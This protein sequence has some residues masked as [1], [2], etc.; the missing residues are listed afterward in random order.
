MWR[1]TSLYRQRRRRA[2]YTALQVGGSVL[3][4]DTFDAEEIDYEL[5]PIV[6]A[7]SVPARRHPGL[8]GVSSFAGQL[9]SP[10][11]P[12][13]FL[14]LRVGL[15]SQTYCGDLGN[16]QVDEVRRAVSA[17]ALILVGGI[18]KNT[19]NGHRRYNVVTSHLFLRNVLNE[20]TIR[21]YAI[22]SLFIS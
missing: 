10:T 5:T 9:A 12:P 8:Q 4:A 20:Q 19:R 16:R 7:V 14:T 1:V 17:E 3:V 11:A 2:R 6:T 21:G 18:V 13:T 15:L 22:Q